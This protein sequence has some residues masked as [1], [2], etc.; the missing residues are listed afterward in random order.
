MSSTMLLLQELQQADETLVGV[1]KAAEGGS[2]TAGNGFFYQDGVI[3][4]MG[5][6]Q[7]VGAPRTRWNWNGS[8]TASAVPKMQADSAAAGTWYSSCWSYG[9]GQDSTEGAATLLLA[10]PFQGR[11]QLL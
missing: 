5:H 11:C 2:S 3:Y 1:R 4:R 9:E 7:E 6:L 8:G 10:N